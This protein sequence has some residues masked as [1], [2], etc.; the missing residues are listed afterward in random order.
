MAIQY[1]IAGC[2]L[3]AFG[4]CQ[5]RAQASQD[6]VYAPRAAEYARIV[7]MGQVEDVWMRNGLDMGYETGNK[8]RYHRI[9]RVR[10]LEVWKGGV[11]VGDEVFIVEMNPGSRGGRMIMDER[12]P[13]LFYLDGVDSRSGAY[14]SKDRYVVKRDAR[15]KKCRALYDNPKGQPTIEWAREVNYMMGEL[16]PSEKPFPRM[17]ERPL[18]RSM[19]EVSSDRDGDGWRDDP[20]IENELIMLN[21]LFN[22]MPVSNPP[23]R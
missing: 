1:R 21:L 9:L 5:V 7:F 13:T 22:W 4:L 6:L 3:L 23:T 20:K 10:V 18:Y 19:R 17:A 16:P 2:L 15:W 14:S 12:R 11:K 8:K